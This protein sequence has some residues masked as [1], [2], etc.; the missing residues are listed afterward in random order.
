MAKEELS[1]VKRAERYAADVTVPGGG[2]HAPCKYSEMSEADRLLQRLADLGARIEQLEVRFVQ[3][4]ADLQKV[5]EVLAGMMTATEQH[6]K[7]LRA[8]VQPQPAPAVKKLL[9]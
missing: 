4:A 5:D 2:E 7:I 8:I 9:N 3:M 1:Y 6:G